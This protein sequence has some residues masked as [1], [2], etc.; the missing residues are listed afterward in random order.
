MVK[1]VYKSLS[2]RTRFMKS[3]VNLYSRLNIAGNAIH[4]R[5]FQ[6]IELRELFWVLVSI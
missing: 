3:D 1:Q 2:L 5:R 4:R 6:M